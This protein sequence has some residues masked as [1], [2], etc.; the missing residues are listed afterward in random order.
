MAFCSVV[1]GMGEA[2]AQIFCFFAGGDSSTWPLAC[3]AIISA[4]SSFSGRSWWAR[5][6]QDEIFEQMLRAI[7]RGFT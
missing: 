5:V 7:N 1:M 2:A 3:K 6:G 4:V